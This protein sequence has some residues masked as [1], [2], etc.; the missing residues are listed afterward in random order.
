M[1][2]ET[3]PLAAL[4]DVRIRDPAVRDQDGAAWRRGR[5]AERV[6]REW[7]PLR[8]A[9]IEACLRGDGYDLEE[10]ADAVQKVVGGEPSHILERLRLFLDMEDEGRP[11]AADGLVRPGASA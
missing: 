3:S 2:G 1:Q 5:F 7:N 6:R 11:A 9:A 8:T 10:L 4:R